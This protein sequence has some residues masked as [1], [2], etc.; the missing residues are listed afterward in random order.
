MSIM[1]TSKLTETET[2]ALGV[3]VSMILWRPLSSKSKLLTITVFVDIPEF[4]PK[5]VQATA[6]LIEYVSGHAGEAQKSN[7]II[8]GA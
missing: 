7:G 1:S 6:G 3:A 4:I 5:T 2:P 8:I